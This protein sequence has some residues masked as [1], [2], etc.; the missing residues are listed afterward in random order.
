MA[1]NVTVKDASGNT[2]TIR[3]IDY[4]GTGAVYLP[5]AQITDG[6][7]K[8][9]VDS[10][11]LGLAVGVVPFGTPVYGTVSAAAATMSAGVAAVSAKTSYLDGFDL[12]GLGATAGSAIAVTIAGVL[13]GTLT[14]NI[15]ITAGIS[16]P[17]QVSKRF[18]PALKGSTTNAAI[19]VTV[20]SYGSGNTS[21]SLNTYGRQ[22]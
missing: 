4:L 20:P 15:G 13:G 18:N 12:D 7:N 5:V 11:S 10:V 1:D 21:A 16:T 6:T 9:Q 14:L 17:V 22:Y 19:V 8:V 3:A 2:Q